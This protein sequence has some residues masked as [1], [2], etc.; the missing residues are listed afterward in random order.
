MVINGRILRDCLH[1]KSPGHL[2][3]IAQMLSTCSLNWRHSLNCTMSSM[4]YPIYIFKAVF[5]LRTI[6]TH[7][8]ESTHQIS[9]LFFFF[10]HKSSQRLPLRSS[11]ENLY[12]T[13]RPHAPHL[14]PPRWLEAGCLLSEADPV[15]S[16]S[17]LPGLAKRTAVSVWVFQANGIHCCPSV[18]KC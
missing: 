6:F 3:Y 13:N 15:S 9:N 4:C 10:T 11:L 2:Q 1:F 18:R 8:S 5:S 14:C 16:P 17:H 7:T 12:V